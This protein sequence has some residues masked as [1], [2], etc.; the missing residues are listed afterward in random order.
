MD[1]LRGQPRISSALARVTAAVCGVI[2][3]LSLWFGLHVLFGQVERLAGPVP[4]WWPQWQTFDGAAAVLSIVAAVSLLRL[5]LGMTKTL[6]I[7]A[8][9]GILWR[10]ITVTA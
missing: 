6:A 9:L 7:C 1:Y 2:L 8:T 5:H 10:T 3:N 4:V